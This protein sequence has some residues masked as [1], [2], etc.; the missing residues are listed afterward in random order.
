LQ[1]K[2]TALTV[3]TIGTF[4]AGLDGRILVIGLP[5]VAHQLHASA[6]EV[7]WIGQAYL[8][9]GTVGLLLVGR[10]ADQFGRV[11][12]YNLGFVIFTIGSALSSL[13]Q[14]PFQ[15]IGFRVIQGVGF[16]LLVTNSYA[17]VVDASPKSELGTMLGINQT[18]IRL[19]NVAGL[20]ISGII[21][22]V[23]DWRGLFYVN[24]PI[25]I[26]GTIWAY[27]RLKEISVLD[28]SKKMDWLGFAFF[29]IGLTSVLLGITY[30]S[31]GAGSFD[32]GLSLLLLG[33]LFLAGFS[34]VESK[35]PH[36]LLDLKLFKI[37]S[38]AMG[39][40]AQLMNSVVL[41]TIIVLLAFFFQLAL[42]YS[43]LQAGLAVLPLDATYLVFSLW[44]GKLSDKY[45][46][47]ILA[48]LGL[49]IG[50]VSIFG[51]VAFG[52]SAGY[53]AFAVIIAIIGAGNGIF[54]PTNTRAIVSG[55][56]PDRV[57]I[58]SGFRQT[59]FNIGIT[60][61]YG[62]AILFLTLGIPYILLSPLLQGNL[63]PALIVLARSEFLTGFRYALI[64]LA[65]INAA[66]IVPS[67]IRGK[68]SQPL[69]T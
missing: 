59:M 34:W 36:P 49:V 20:T 54:N 9:A 68:P 16:A 31:Y 60:S 39:G 50:T 29:S 47:Q 19:G 48:T 21:L 23:V 63:A 1:Y 11:K 3:T 2:W 65:A 15:L 18:A 27:K 32:F 38:F 8:L 44:G 13:A 25:G 45:P 56:P 7:I 40:I 4:M 66:A 64:I 62:V 14:D 26:F 10:V 28:P 55:V 61:S 42:G 51:M 17:I 67:L 41:N 52:V 33:F 69:T 46:P 37:R 30:L 43:P 12:L 5:T 22:A 6:T 35:T 58:A 53:A 57:G 24:I